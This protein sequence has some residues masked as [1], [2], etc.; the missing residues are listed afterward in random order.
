MRLSPFRKLGQSEPEPPKVETEL[1]RALRG[2]LQAISSEAA[3]KFRG[4]MK[5]KMLV[6]VVTQAFEAASDEQLEEM[7]RVAYDHISA[8][9]EV[10]YPDSVKGSVVTMSLPSR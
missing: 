8:L 9:Y 7:L 6:G 4:D 10:A 5:V 3:G 2:K 1:R